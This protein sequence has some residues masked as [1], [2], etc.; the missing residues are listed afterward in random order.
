VTVQYLQMRTAVAQM[1]LEKFAGYHNLREKDVQRIKNLRPWLSATELA[2][3]YNLT[4]SVM[5]KLLRLIRHADGDFADKR[6]KQLIK[7]GSHE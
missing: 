7:G 1:R 5:E 2:R 6:P 4:N 3:L